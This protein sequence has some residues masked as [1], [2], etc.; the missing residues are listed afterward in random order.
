MKG[1]FLACVWIA[2]SSPLMALSWHGVRVEREKALM[3]LLIGTLILLHQS[4]TQRS[5]SILITSLKRGNQH[6]RLGS[7]G[8][9]TTHQNQIITRNQFTWFHYLLCSNSNQDCVVLAER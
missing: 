6:I 8:D 4:P 3:S 9:R 5:H 2:M 7:S 1:L